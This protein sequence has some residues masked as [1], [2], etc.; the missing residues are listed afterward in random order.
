MAF[1]KPRPPIY[2]L[3]AEFDTPEALLDAARRAYDAGYRRMDAYS[4]FPVEG[5]AEAL[6]SRRTLVSAIV[7][8]GL[9][10]NAT[11][12]WS[13]ADPVAALVV[14][15]V[16]VREGVQAW[17]GE[18]CDDCAVPAVTVPDGAGRGCGCGPDCA[19]RCCAGTATTS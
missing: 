6:G 13:W 14:A 2:G 19:D 18:Q 1:L 12:G 5:L 17:R 15:T 7:L 3:M 11:L 10:V 4:P 8:V 9:L 16:A